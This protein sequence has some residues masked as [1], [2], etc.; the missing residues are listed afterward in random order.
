[1]EARP[2]FVTPRQGHSC[3]LAPFHVPCCPELLTVSGITLGPG[4]SSD[5][6]FMFT[7]S[8]CGKPQLSWFQLVKRRPHQGMERKHSVAGGHMVTNPAQILS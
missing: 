6:K 8:E 7:T 3:G 2:S 5:P 4:V 1:M